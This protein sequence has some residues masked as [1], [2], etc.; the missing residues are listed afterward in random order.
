MRALRVVFLP[1][2]RGNPYL[3]Q[4][5]EHLSR[6][7]VDVLRFD[8]TVT[9]IL[10]GFARERPDILH[11]HW[12]D[13]FF[14]ASDTPRALI[15]LTA[16]VSAVL[17]LKLLRRRIVWTVHNLKA[18]E[19]R[20]PKLDRLCT[21]FVAKR[22]DAIIVHCEAARRAL[23]NEF[24]LKETDKVSVIPHG[25]YRDVYENKIGR[26]E[27]RRVLGVDERRLVLLFF[28]QIRPYKGV[29]E[30]IDA[31]AALDHDEVELVMAGK[32]RDV[33]SAEV[34]RGR[35]AGR[36]RIMYKPGFVADDQVQVYMNACDAVVSPYRDILTSG[37]VIL[38][39]SFGRACIAPRMG[40][41]AETLDDAGAFLYEPEDS[42]GLANA[43]KRA[44]EHKADLQAMGEHNR[45]LAAP[46][47]WD[48]IARMTLDVYRR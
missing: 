35:C 6:L 39:M 21:A 17:V 30:L 31:F 22:A 8:Q 28:G 2:F 43:M 14:V 37:A 20:N 4:L 41:I 40:C 48:R 44:I 32:P 34:I 3:G 19:D 46:W 12:L 13:P 38:A 16:F 42:D 25:H 11:L 10:M 47:G 15:K 26:S 1:R 9:S 5:E 45:R 24:G 29:L 27:A 23:V 18:H 33:A 7:G 36:P